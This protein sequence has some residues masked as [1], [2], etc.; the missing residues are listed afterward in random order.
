MTPT[1][2][3]LQGLL[4]KKSAADSLRSR[5]Q[6]AGLCFFNI[7]PRATFLIKHSQNGDP[8]SLF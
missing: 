6:D 5:V 2:Y 4:K 8:Q 7:Y 1:N 3:Q